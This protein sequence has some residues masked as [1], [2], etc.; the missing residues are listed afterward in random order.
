M[1]FITSLFQA[2]NQYTRLQ[3]TTAYAYNRSDKP[4]SLGWG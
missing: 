4:N 3:A 2:R 1:R